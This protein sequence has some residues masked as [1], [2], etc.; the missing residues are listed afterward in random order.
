MSWDFFAHGEFYLTMAGIGIGVIGL[1]SC[2]HGVRIF[3]R[4]KIN[5]SS[6][7][8]ILTGNAPSTFFRAKL[9]AIYRALIPSLLAIAALLAIGFS[10]VQKMKPN[11]ALLFAGSM[12]L[13]PLFDSLVGFSFGAASKE[14]GRAFLWVILSAVWAWIGSIIGTPLIMMITNSFKAG[15]FAAAIAALIISIILIA[16]SRKWTPAQL[17][18]LLAASVCFM[19]YLWAFLGFTSRYNMQIGIATSL[20]LQGLLAVFWYVFGVRI[21]DKAMRG[22]G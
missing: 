4:E 5:N 19:S 17:S 2:F 9:R 15:M 22:D 12:L 6:Q 14:S 20:W 8:L 1:S 13:A 10:M 18:L 16:L 3:A 11:Y 7:A 21:F